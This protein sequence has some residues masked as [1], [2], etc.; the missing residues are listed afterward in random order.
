LITP[1]LVR[2]ATA[3]IFWRQVRQPKA[4]LILGALLLLGQALIT[5]FFRS[6]QD[7]NFLLRGALT[8]LMLLSMLG[9][10]GVAA[11]YYVGMAQAN[12]ARIVGVPVSVELDEQ[13]YRYNASWGQGSIEWGRFDSLW[14]FPQVWVL[15]QHL[16]GGVSVVLP[17]KDLG[18]EAQAFILRKLG[19]A[20]AK[21]LA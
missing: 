5:A 8:L 13:A 21:V 11:R 14:R 16:S 3:G 17:L 4:L 20:G 18:P 7:G 6:N 12:F 9:V 19:Q 15:L 2:Q 10:A 1:D